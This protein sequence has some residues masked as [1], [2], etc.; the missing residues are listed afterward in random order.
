MAKYEQEMKHEQVSKVRAREQSVSKRAAEGSKEHV[1][2]GGLSGHVSVKVRW[3][4]SAKESNLGFQALHP[5]NIFLLRALL[6][7]IL[8]LM[9]DM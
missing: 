2:R 1:D 7:D 9:G 3:M 4:K 8:I 6:S 5:L